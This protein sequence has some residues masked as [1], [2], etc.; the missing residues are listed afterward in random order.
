MQ[1]QTYLDV[2][3]TWQPRYRLA[4]RGPPVYVKEAG[5]SGF[6]FVDCEWVLTEESQT[7]GLEI[8]QRAL[9]A[10]K[11]WKDANRQ[12]ATAVAK[13][14]ILAAV[15]KVFK[16][17]SIALTVCPDSGDHQTMLQI[18]D[19][20][21]SVSAVQGGK[22]VI[23]QRSK[24]GETPFGWHLHFMIQCT[25]APSKIKQFVQQKLASRGYVA[26]YYATQADANWLNKY[27]SGSKGNKDKDAKV[28]Q[29]RA[30][31]Q[32]LGLQ[33]IYDIPTKALTT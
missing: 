33:D 10:D 1:T 32:Q 27:M 17:N 9:E 12:I 23:E 24:P 20:V 18:A 6:S 30:L 19:I 28:Q 2:L 25:Y 15:P 22:Y 8:A 11:I 21:A 29:D 31:R 14:Q 13:A 4:P 26:T 7:E 3:S 5:E 16:A